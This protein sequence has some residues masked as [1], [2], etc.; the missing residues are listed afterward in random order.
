MTFD[1]LSGQS[2]HN[3]SIYLRK[4]LQPQTSCNTVT[5]YLWTQKHLLIFNLKCLGSVKFPNAMYMYNKRIISSFSMHF[6]QKFFLKKYLTY[7][8]PRPA[9]CLLF[10]M[11]G[12][13]KFEVVLVFFLICFFL[14][15][16]AVSLAL[17]FI[18]I[19]VNHTGWTSELITS[20]TIWIVHIT[21][22]SVTT[23][24]C[25]VVKVWVIKV[26]VNVRSE[27]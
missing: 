11:F 17:R 1:W 27:L 23:L 20:S 22:L 10:H 9:A 26:F 18:V 19:W 16:L 14:G 3:S 13:F 2:L 24:I 8:L 5:Y 12:S 25:I 15:S 21:S 6:V 7:E 4:I